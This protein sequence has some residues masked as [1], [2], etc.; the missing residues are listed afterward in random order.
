M[1]K[2]FQSTSY[3]QIVLVVLAGKLWL[4][5]QEIATFGT[6]SALGVNQK[7]YGIQTSGESTATVCLTKRDGLAFV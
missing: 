6:Y 4:P 5:S 3:M 1:K 2:D 7:R